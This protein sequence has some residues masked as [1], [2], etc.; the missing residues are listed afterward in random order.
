MRRVLL[1]LLGL[2]LLAILSYYCFKDKEET[3]RKGLTAATSTALQK[4]D[5]SDVKV[6]LK[7]S[8]VTMQNIIRLEG[9]V[10]SQAISSQAE[11]IAKGV[12]G[13][14]G[15]VNALTFAKTEE[16]VVAEDTPADVQTD[17]QADA[18]AP[19]E[20]NIT[21]PTTEPAKEATKEED[22]S[23]ADANISSYTLAITKDEKK[24]LTLD[25]YVATTKQQETL[26][27]E[28]KK[29]FGDTHV[30]DKLQIKEGAP[31]EWMDIASFAIDKLKD[32][33]Y[34]D[35]KL[36][37]TEYEF[38]AHL[39]SPSMKEAFLN[40]I[41]V[42]MSDP[43]NKYGRYKGDYIITAPIEEPESGGDL[44][45]CQAALDTLLKGKKVLFDFNKASI[46]PTSYALLESIIKE[47]KKC[48]VSLLEITGHTDSQGD[49]NYNK[50]LSQRRAESV[51]KYFVKKGFSKKRLRAIGLGETAPIASNET[52]DGRIKNRR[53]EFK[54]KEVK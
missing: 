30:D 1:A 20:E 34:G 21:E 28:A 17:V 42:A 12:L 43:E 35:M 31:K 47:A 10:P 36:H 6:S 29:L 24:N 9:E 46:Q 40:N 19:V 4:S 27:A 50:V 13:V 7:G 39:P 22:A 54:I 44:K 15:V 23:V 14:G 8:D 51:V 2:L 26:L 52:V 18:T 38:T 53:I 3:I 33:D 11:K 49:A 25:G 5:I 37:G 16:P 48:H 41:K 32:V 45:T